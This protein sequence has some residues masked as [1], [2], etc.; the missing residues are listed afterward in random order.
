MSIINGSGN[1]FEDLGL[2]NPAEREAKAQVAI[3]IENLIKHNGWTQAEAAEHMGIN[4]SDVSNIVRGRLS[5]FT[6]DRLFRCLHE[7]NFFAAGRSAQCPSDTPIL[8]DGS[9]SEGL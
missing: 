2:P 3:Y 7:M 6:L 5:T 9:M 8:K 4:Q 1:V